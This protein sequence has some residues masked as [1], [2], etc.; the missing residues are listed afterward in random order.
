MVVR[1]D[2]GITDKLNSQFGEYHVTYLDNASLIGRWKQLRKDFAILVV[3]PVNCP[4]DR[5]KVTV[6]FSWAHYRRRQLQF[7]IDSWADVYFRYDNATRKYVVDNVE[8]AG[9]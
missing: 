7:R 6:H 5:L 2:P 8:L 1:K 4:E 3:E 9:V